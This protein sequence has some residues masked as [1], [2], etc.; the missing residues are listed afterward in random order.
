MLWLHLLPSL[1]HLDL[2][3]GEV[4]KVRL[5]LTGRWYRIFLGLSHTVR[6]ERTQLR[7]RRRSMDNGRDEG[8]GG[9]SDADRRAIAFLLD[10]GTGALSRPDGIRD[11]T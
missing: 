5:C 10:D 7:C 6:A 4:M 11:G 1:M 8:V 3:L 2:V 9:A